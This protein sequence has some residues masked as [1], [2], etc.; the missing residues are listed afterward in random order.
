MKS[1]IAENIKAVFGTLGFLFVLL[2]IILIGIPYKIISSPNHT[3]FFNIGE[4]RYLGLAPIVVGGII[5]FWCSFSFVFSGKGTPIHSMPPKELVVKGLY[6]FVRNT[7]YIAGLLVLAGEVLLFQSKGVFIYLLVMFGMFHFFVLGH[8]E[9]RLEKRFG[10]PYK[11][12]RKSVRRWIPR[13]APY[14]EYDSESQ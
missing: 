1:D 9:S 3:H 11:R 13:L 8:E 2:P 4:F 6:R 14:R 5:Y 10:E 12:Y 7:M